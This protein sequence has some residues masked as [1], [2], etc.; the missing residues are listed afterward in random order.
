MD[1]MVKLGYFI[2]INIRAYL[3]D[4]PAFSLKIFLLC[5]KMCPFPFL[6]GA[7][8]TDDAVINWIC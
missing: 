4:M 2:E 6:C 8:N 7:V 3:V 5:G 1:S